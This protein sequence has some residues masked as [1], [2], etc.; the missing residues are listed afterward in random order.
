MRISDAPGSLAARLSAVGLLGVALAA[1]VLWSALAGFG[2]VRE[3]AQAARLI[4]EAQRHH[5]DA[6]MAHDAL[7]ADV[8]EVLRATREGRDQSEALGSCGTT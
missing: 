3:S 6:D 5:Q 7:H 2:N 8:L 1:A 4:S